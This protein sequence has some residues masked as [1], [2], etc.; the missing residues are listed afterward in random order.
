MLVPYGALPGVFPSWVN[1]VRRA[2]RYGKNGLDETR[3]SVSSGT[4]STAR[5]PR[6]LRVPSRTTSNDEG[7]GFRPYTSSSR[8]K[9]RAMCA[10]ENI[11]AATRARAAASRFPL[12][13]DGL[14]AP[15]PRA[16]PDSRW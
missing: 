5:S 16:N 3:I 11:S 10:S 8:V 7:R 1:A 6:G 2:A 12:R 15:P 4:V 9:G 14:N 13:L